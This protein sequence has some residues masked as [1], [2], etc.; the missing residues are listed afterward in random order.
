MLYT[1]YSVIPVKPPN[2]RM[3]KKLRQ[4]RFFQ[5]DKAKSSRAG[6]WKRWIWLLEPT[7]IVLWNTV[8]CVLSRGAGNLGRDNYWW[9]PV[10]DVKKNSRRMGTLLPQ[11][12][13]LADLHLLMKSPWS[14]QRCYVLTFCTVLFLSMKNFGLF[15]ARLELRE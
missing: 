13:E 6:M 10:R 15:E 12:E 2:L 11:G 7:A 3:K 14:R 4:R 1:H 9:L 8:P 5:G